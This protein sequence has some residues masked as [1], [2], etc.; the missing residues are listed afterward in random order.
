MYG[1][2]V[3]HNR[4]ATSNNPL[5]D[6]TVTS[7]VKVLKSLFWCMICPLEQL[8][9]SHPPPVDGPL[10]LVPGVSPYER[11]D[12]ILELQ[13]SAGLTRDNTCASIH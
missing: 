2:Y 7:G 4:K 11:F 8:F 13:Y 3:Q 9:F 10:P 5:M 1:M 6:N 12:R